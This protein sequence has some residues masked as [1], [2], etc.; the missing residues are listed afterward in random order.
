M[1]NLVAH[2]G[3]EAAERLESELNGEEKTKIFDPLMSLHYH[4][5]GEALRCGGLYLMGENV[6]GD[7]DGQYCPICEFTQHLD[8]FDAPEEINNIAAQMAVWARTEHLIPQ[9]N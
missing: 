2:D 9:V 5:C 3:D 4:F 7:N 8:G 1:S 6:T